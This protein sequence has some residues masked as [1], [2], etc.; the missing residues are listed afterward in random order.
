MALYIGRK[1]CTKILAVYQC[2][3]IYFS[4][5]PFL[6]LF[7]THQQH[8]PFAM[9]QIRKNSGSDEP[10]NEQNKQPDGI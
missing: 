6:K 2:L 5:L 9:E 8:H 7:R 3:F 10:K 4:L 1:K